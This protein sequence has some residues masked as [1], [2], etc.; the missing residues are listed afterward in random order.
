MAKVLEKDG[1][2]NI[3]IRGQLPSL[4]DKGIAKNLLCLFNQVFRTQQNN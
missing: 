2:M 1:Q 3:A 4:S